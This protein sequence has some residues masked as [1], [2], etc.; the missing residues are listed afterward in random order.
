[1]NSLCYGASTTARRLR[2]GNQVVGVCVPYSVNDQIFCLPGFLPQGCDVCW[3][4]QARLNETLT[5]WEAE[6]RL[7]G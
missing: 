3:V 1:M 5:Y 2:K 6:G 4:D 7:V